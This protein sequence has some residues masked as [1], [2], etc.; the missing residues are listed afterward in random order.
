MPS[1][2]IKQSVHSADVQFNC[3]LTAIKTLL[4]ASSACNDSRSVP[5]QKAPWLQWR[6]KTA[7]FANEKLCIRGSLYIEIMSALRISLC[8]CVKHKKVH[9][10]MRRWCLIRENVFVIFAKYIYFFVYSEGSSVARIEWWNVVHRCF[11]F[12]LYAKNSC[13]VTIRLIYAGPVLTPNG[14]G[15][16]NYW[17]CAR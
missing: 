14:T 1:W 3:G 7:L 2:Q 12:R 13:E 15:R 5:P 11:R 17:N 4:I 10:I 16:S 6:C 8:S 9:K